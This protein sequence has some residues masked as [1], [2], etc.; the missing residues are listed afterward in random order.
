VVQDG[1]PTTVTPNPKQGS[2]THNDCVFWMKNNP[3]SKCQK[4]K[5]LCKN[6]QM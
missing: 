1:E 3:I 2:E 6:C 4:K 5:R